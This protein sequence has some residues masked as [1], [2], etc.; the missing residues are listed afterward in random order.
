M[1]IK[2]Q[3]L[4]VTYLGPTLQKLELAAENENV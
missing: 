1:S 4:L 2:K 3:L